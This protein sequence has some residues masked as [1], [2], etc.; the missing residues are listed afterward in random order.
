MKK[1]I[2]KPSNWQDFESL[3]KMLWGEIWGI[4]DKIKQN[5]RLGQLQ[6]GVDIY[7]VP[8]DKQ[9]YSG[10]QCK[11]KNDDLKSV[12][13]TKE[14][15]T[16]INNAKTFVP[17][18]ETFI[19]A[20]TAN[21]DVKLE[22]YIR[23]KDMESRAN[24][25]FEILLY[26]WEDI[27]DLIETN[28]HTFNYYVSKNQFKTNFEFELTFAD[29]EKTNTISPKFRKTT[30][31]YA[32]K[33]DPE[34]EH[35]KNVLAS[36]GIY[37]GTFSNLP[38]PS[39]RNGINASWAK[40]NLQFKN[41]GSVTIED[42]KIYVTPEKDKIRDM[43]HQLNSSGIPI[44]QMPHDPFYVFEKEKYGVYKRTDNAPLIQKDP[45]NIS[46]YLLVNWDA[47]EIKIKYEL[48]ARDFNIE[49]ELTLII[50]PTYDE[51]EKIVKVDTQ[52]DIQADTVEIGDYMK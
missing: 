22:Q 28:R 30:T 50:A 17:A 14:I 26:C 19:F 44:L 47:T 38:K 13:T 15:D 6:S 3:C 33:S 27:S 36:I 1:L 7:G 34:I 8:K 24:G 42:F 37:Q 10:I 45:K 16:E 9:K 40:V 21:K 39:L 12:L 11:G 31:K 20:T 18:L 51:V 46:F 4:P 52:Q 2:Q 35:E 32:L 5:G 48:L 41:T 29:G 43:K 23:E 25:G 49:D